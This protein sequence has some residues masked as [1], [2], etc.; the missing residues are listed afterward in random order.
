MEKQLVQRTPAEGRWIAQSGDLNRF[1]AVSENTGG[2][3]AQWEAIV[4]PGGGPRLH[5]H[6]RE[7]E[8]FYVLQGEVQFLI[9][10]VHQ[11][12]PEGSYVSLP[13]G[14]SHRFRNESAG[15]A[16][17]LITVTP[18]GLEGVFFEAGLEVEPSSAVAPSPAGDERE[19]IRV[20]ALRYGITLLPE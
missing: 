9:D 16:R 10:G 6:S 2:A 14:T 11:A 3:Y 19:K 5:V 15:I 20:T 7:D 12:A 13:A 8:T 1:L 17:L 4:P 18:G